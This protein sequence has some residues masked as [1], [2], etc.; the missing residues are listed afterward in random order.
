MENIFKKLSFLFLIFTLSIAN[1]FAATDNK[2]EETKDCLTPVEISNKFGN[3]T[4]GDHDISMYKTCDSFIE[5]VDSKFLNVATAI[6]DKTTFDKLEPVVTSLGGDHEELRSYFKDHVPLQDILIV[7]ANIAVVIISIFLFYIAIDSAL[8]GALKGVITV[9]A[10]V[11]MY[12]ASSNLPEYATRAW[13]FGVSKVNNLIYEMHEIERNVQYF[14]GNNKLEPALSVIDKQYKTLSQMLHLG[15]AVDVATG[16]SITKSTYGSN[17][18]VDT[19][20]TYLGGFDIGQPTVAEF[21]EQNDECLAKD[22]V[23]TSS[24][25]EFNVK[26]WSDTGMLRFIPTD[27]RVID[28]PYRASFHNGGETHK[29]DCGDDAFGNE[30]AFM[31]IQSNN[32]NIAQNFVQ[33]KTADIINGDTTMIENMASIISN[34]LFYIEEELEKVDVV[35]GSIQ[36]NITGKIALAYAAAKEAQV[37]NDNYRNTNTY[38]NLVSDFENIARPVFIYSGEENFTTTEVAEINALKLFQASFSM[39]FTEGSEDEVLEQHVNGWH[40]LKPFVEKTV[41][42]QMAVDCAKQ[43]KSNGNGSSTYAFRE[44]YAGRWNAMDK[45][46]VKNK[47]MTD[48]GG[49]F[50]Y[51]CFVMEDGY[52]NAEYSDPALIEENERDINARAQAIEIMMSA[53]TK[54]VFNASQSNNDQMWKDAKLEYLNNIRPTLQSVIESQFGFL[55]MKRQM[56]NVYASVGE[57]YTYDIKVPVKEL[58]QSQFFFNHNRFSSDVVT[59]E[60]MKNTI[61]SRGLKSYS[62]ST[63]FNADTDVKFSEIDTGFSIGDIG[64]TSMLRE[65]ISSGDCPVK[66]KNGSC[67]ASLQELNYTSTDKIEDMAI[68]FT[69][70]SKTIKMTRYFGEGVGDMADTADN[71][72]V[73]KVPGPQKLLIWMGKAMKAIAIAVDVTL[74]W[75]LDLVVGLV[76]LLVLAGKLARYMPLITEIVL[77]VYMVIYFVVPLCLLP[78]IPVIEVFKSAVRKFLGEQQPMN[79][80]GTIMLIKVSTI[81]WIV[82]YLAIKL[83]V[84]INTSPAIGGAIYHMVIGAFPKNNTGIMMFFMQNITLSLVYIWA[85]WKTVPIV[86][87]LEN[88]I[89]RLMN[90]AAESMFK[91]TESFMKIITTVGL[92]KLHGYITQG[93]R[94]VNVGVQ[95]G[96]EKVGASVNKAIKAY[97]KKQTSNPQQARAVDVD[98]E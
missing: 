45:S 33:G 89:L 46:S 2:L 10:C 56:E 74:G 5:K 65:F 40:Y 1:A 12:F 67:K 58:T 57:I 32:L 86:N 98:E 39:L 11:V 81:R 95:K 44:E 61:E 93:N 63:I 47:T 87:E 48:I 71:T 64:I 79:F 41:R 62:L 19:N 17:I 70:I 16:N 96:S 77:H 4:E 94:S 60:D 28:I 7:T 78:I 52:M 54:G 51:A 31:T 34:K 14:D 82:F 15:V 85:I 20:G 66:G 36:Q 3:F 55:D 80:K 8:N 6:I 50:D 59:E 73:G 91:E 49:G 75:M 27:A 24:N 23:E 69:V 90:V 92:T 21:F 38:Q 43:T 18:I 35:F 37:K 25:Y 22:R 68:Y 9:L 88:Q 13:L 42:M 84:F 30:Q 83:L 26:T 76:W 53:L 72:V 97:R 29:Y